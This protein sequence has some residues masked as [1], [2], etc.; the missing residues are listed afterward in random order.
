MLWW[1][2]T[3]LS[4][5]HIN[6]KINS[7][8]NGSACLLH[9]MPFN[10]F[11]SCSL[12]ASLC[13]MCVLCCVTAYRGSAPCWPCPGWWSFSPCWTLSVLCCC[14]TGLCSAPCC[15]CTGPSAFL[16]HSEAFWLR[17]GYNPHLQNV[18]YLEEFALL[19]FCLRNIGQNAIYIIAHCIL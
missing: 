11:L 15:F 2:Y 18:T 7:W 17:Y 5:S 14:A 4:R 9:F 19:L 8:I 3:E 12:R 13:W 10:L 6:W 16:T 1:S